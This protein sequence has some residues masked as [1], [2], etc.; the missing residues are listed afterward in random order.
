MAV[1]FADGKDPYDT[2]RWRPV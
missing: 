1:P 2:E